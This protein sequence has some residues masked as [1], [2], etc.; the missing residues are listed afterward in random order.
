MVVAKYHVGLETIWLLD[1]VREKLNMPV[2]CTCTVQFR[3][4]IYIG[5]LYQHATHVDYLP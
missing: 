2:Y 3:P 4:W 1:M 5:K